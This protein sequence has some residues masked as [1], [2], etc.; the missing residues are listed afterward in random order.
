MA[1]LEKIVLSCS[2]FDQFS[3]SFRDVIAALPPETVK[4]LRDILQSY[5]G[6]YGIEGAC[7]RMNNRTVAQILAESQAVD[8]E[9]IASGEIDNVQYKLYEGPSPQT[10]DGEGSDDNSV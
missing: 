4:R 3:N 2:S 10:N 7:R 5:F 6:K 8:V 9:P 1:D